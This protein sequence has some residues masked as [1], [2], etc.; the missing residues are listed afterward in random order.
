V[1][2]T[3]VQNGRLPILLQVVSQCTSTDAINGS[4]LYAAYD[5]INNINTDG[6]NFQ[7]N[8][9]TV[10][11][12]DL[13]ETLSIVGATKNPVGITYDATNAA[14]V[15]TY[16]AQ[17]IQTVTDPAGNIQIQFAERPV[18]DGVTLGDATKNL[19]TI[20]EGGININKGT[21]NIVISGDT[22]SFGGN[23]INN[24]AAGVSLTDA[25]NVSQLNNLGNSLTAA[26]LNFSDNK[27]NVSHRNLGQ[28]LS[29]VGAT[30]NPVT[31]AYDT[32]NAATV[33]TYSAQNVQTVTD[34][35]GNMQIQ[36]AERPVFDG[37]T[38][39][40]ATKN[41]VTINEGGIN[42]NKGTK[43]IVISGDT[44]SFGGNVIN[45]VAAG[46]SL[47]DAV[48]V[49]QLNNLGNSL[50]AAG[51][52][53][54]DNKGNVS[55]RN[56]GQTLSIVGAT[57]NPVTIAYDTTNAATVGTYSAQNVQT[58]TDK[59]G[60]MQIQFAE[61]PVFDGVTLGDATKNLVTINEGGINI[62][63]GTKNIVISGDTVSFGGNVINNVAAGVS[64][65]DAVNVS[66]LNNLGNS[67]TAAG[68]N[69][70]DN[71]GNV[72]HRNLGQT[73]SIVGATVNPVTIAYDTTNAATV[74]TYSAQNV[75]T[76]TDKN[77]NM[78]IQ[79]AERPVF[80]GVTLGDATKNLVTI[81]EGGININKGTKNIV[82]SGDTVSFG[83][84]VINNVA[85]GVSLTDAVNVS[86]L[87]N[88]GNSLTAAGLNFSDNKGNVS[89]RNLGQTL[90][91]V[92]ATV[93]PVTIAYDTTNAATVGTYSAQNVQTVTDKNGNMQIQFAER[94]VFDGV[95]LGDATKNLV[96]INEGGI[97]INKGT[98]NIVIS[99]DTV[100]FGGNVINNV[101][102]G[103]SLT[104]AVNVSQLNN[105]GNS[106]TAAGLNFSDNKGNVSHRNLGQTLSIV[107]ATV[108]PVTIAYDTTNAAT[109]GTYSAQNVQTVTDKNGNMQIQFA[110]RPVFDGVT[111]GD[112]TKNLVTI[113]EG[114]ININK[115]TKNIVISGDTVSFGGNVINNVAAGVSLTDA[116]NVSQL[117]N[118][119]N[120]LTAAGLNFSDNKGNV[121]HRNLGQTL[122]IVG[123]TV[124]PVTIAYDTTNAATVGTYSAQNVQTVTDKNGNM[125]IQFA[126][127]PVFDGVTLGDATKNLV[128]INEGGININKGT[129]NIVI[130][131]DTVSFGGNVI[132]NIAA[133]VSLT[134]AV[135]VS[136]LNNLGNSLT[137][138]GLNFSDN[139]GNVSHRNLGQT[140]SIVGA[141]V[142]P[143]TIAYDTTN[144]ATVGT[145][146]AQNVQTVTD[147]NG[148]MQIQFAERP[149]FDGVTLGDATKN[150]VTIN[151]GGI[152]INKGT[153]N[154]V[155][156]GDTV[157]FGGNVINN[158]AAGV[159][160]PLV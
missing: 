73:L 67:L 51:L 59:N 49:S 130:S 145:Y 11:H 32:T 37:V 104:D 23:V 128:T 60:N 86:Q 93:N 112:A 119:G 139:K 105:L 70:S 124:N 115:G 64:L 110:E 69:F 137:A 85:A 89:H 6:L 158:V 100:S 150:L 75:Q 95:T 126:E 35:N 111:L 3:L 153:K 123:A 45:N 19:V 63:K 83:G 90:S 8:S 76:V 9:G 120:S 135:N 1:L 140:L 47:T 97:N 38:L 53:F 102:A 149:V 39:G 66:Q 146:S 2:V 71:K 143:V 28:T 159:S 136:Q 62:N 103:V 34:K 27:G 92:G 20:N 36:F 131:G 125:Q 144:A 65:T 74:G 61:R 84:N 132:N 106:L 142:N 116:V 151:E 155:I 22:V 154:I 18:F 72:S 148:N 157:S 13:G 50:T 114:G 12:R 94:P 88:L 80:D 17:N 40:D 138:A 48:N 101:A 127:R 41:L 87:N 5:A 113:N 156:S 10:G 14:T 99:G 54:S 117:N 98:K 134:D 29:I 147:K 91:I 78:Q 108:N 25:V 30:V 16:S 118:L 160:L 52:N 121:S 77:G 31:I 33:G 55:H 82:I 57:V 4:Q 129:K 24:V 42:I 109:V 79:F 44:V 43:N 122:S 68:L 152:N 81:N 15:G 26:G 46:V 133:G 58:V 96:T 21:K 7:G 141:T 107:G 56:L